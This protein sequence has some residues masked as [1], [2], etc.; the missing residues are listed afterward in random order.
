MPKLKT[1]KAKDKRVIFPFRL[2]PKDK[3]QFAIFAAKEGRS[4]QEM[5][6][7]ALTDFFKKHKQPPLK[8]VLQKKA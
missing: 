2:D 6:E 4:M 7:E 5:L 8:S 1:K 3:R